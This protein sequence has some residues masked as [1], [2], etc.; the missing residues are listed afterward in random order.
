MGSYLFVIS[1]CDIKTPL[2]KQNQTKNEANPILFRLEPAFN[3]GVSRY[4]P[5]SNTAE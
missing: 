3:T 5:T 2:M 4:V 1:K